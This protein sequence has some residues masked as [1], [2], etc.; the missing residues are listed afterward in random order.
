[1]Y[2]GLGDRHQALNFFQQALPMTREIGDR[3]GEA[4]TLNNIG[5]VYETLVNNGLRCVGGGPV[6]GS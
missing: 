4:V 1:M 2:A 3:A 5:Q 6:G